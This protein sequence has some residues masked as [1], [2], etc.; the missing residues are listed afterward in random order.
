MSFF[1]YLFFYI[2]YF[3]PLY[4]SLKGGIKIKRHII[5]ITIIIFIINLVY[6][7]NKYNRFYKSITEEVNLEA[8]VISENQK[9]KYYNSYIIKGKNDLYKSKKFTL[10]TKL[11]LDYGDKI[12][13]EGNFYKPYVA[14]NYKGFNQMQYFKS[15]NIYGTI[16]SNNIEIISNNAL[17][18]IFT[19]SNRVKNKI[20]K[21][22]KTLLEEDT[23]GLLI[24]II[25]GD[26]TGIKEETIQNFQKSSLAHILA[27]SGAHI[28]YIILG[29]TFLITYSKIPK[30]IGY[31]IIIICL[32]FFLF[33]TN[34]LTSAI[35]ASIMAI[36]I[37]ISKLLHRKTD[38]I[39]TITI[40]VLITIINNP[41]SIFNISIQL[42]YLGT[43][44]VIFV[45]PIIKQGLL[46]LKTNI[47]IAKI[48]SIPL[49]AYIT[50]LPI[51]VLKFKTLSITFL[52]SNIIAIP[53][54]GFIIIGGII[55]LFIS[56]LW[57]W[58]AKKIA[59]V[60][61]L[62]LKALTWI[63]NIFGSFKISNIYVITPNKISVL[64][65]YFI[66]FITVYIFN[67]K[68]SNSFNYYEEKFLNTLNSINIKKILVFF[69]IIIIV[70]EFPYY[71]YNGQLK[72]FFIDVGQRR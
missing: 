54:L 59:I 64:I 24:G 17:N 6:S 25:V 35:R 72:I 34:F 39:N 28:S 26:K 62:L 53:L 27:V 1:V 58:L 65:Y 60:L 7:N 9:T 13:L 43:I 55:T 56:F 32:L 31:I 69:L 3:N 48:I 46:R 49:S 14:K 40:A 11:K 30:K 71:K 10:Y 23:G 19:I 47:K 52:L 4:L 20:I 15:N 21:N 44:G 36:T 16:K 57:L 51:T 70:L 61:A 18:H 63:A 42:S 37:I 66:L 2:F 5:T 8:V 33:L 68:K 38:T 12:S 45:S 67:L 29:L 41:F 50:I 22:I